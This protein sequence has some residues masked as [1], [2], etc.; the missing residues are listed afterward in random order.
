MTRKKPEKAP[1]KMT[2][3]AKRKAIL[4]KEIGSRIRDVRKNLHHTQAELVGSFPCGRA[5]Y[6]RIEKG[7]VFPNPIILKVLREQYR[8]SLHWLICNEGQMIEQEE[9]KDILAIKTPADG[10]EAEEIKKLFF[11]IDNVPLVKH[12]VL[13]FFLEFIGKNKKLIE[14]DLEKAPNVKAVNGDNE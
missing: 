10:K 11:Y 9:E 8:V 14:P 1:K 5:N 13:G 7:E 6:S 2:P 12:A 3:R 4:K